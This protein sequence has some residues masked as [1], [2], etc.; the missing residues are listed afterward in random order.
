MNPQFSNAGGSVEKPCFTLIAK[1]DKKPPY[2]IATECGQLAIEIYETDSGPMRKIKEFMALYG[3]VDIKMRM[4]K[5]IELKRIMGF[6]ENYTLIGTQ[7]RP[8]EVYRQCGR[9]E[10]S[11]CSMRSLGRRNCRRTIKSCIEWHYE[12]LNHRNP[13]KCSLRWLLPAIYFSVAEQLQNLTFQSIKGYYWPTMNA[14]AFV[15]ESFL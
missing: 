11:P 15:L 8:K 14:G 5:I 12:L 10:Y 13:V 7:G 6:P 2:L 1:M 9:S 3:I 4:L